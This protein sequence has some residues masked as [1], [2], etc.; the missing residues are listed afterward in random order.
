MIKMKQFEDEGASKELAEAK[1]SNFLL[2][3]YR[4]KLSSLYLS[5]IRWFHA[6]KSDPAHKN[7]MATVRRFMGRR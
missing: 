7:V 2:T 3:A 5:Y 1:A 4:K 6:L